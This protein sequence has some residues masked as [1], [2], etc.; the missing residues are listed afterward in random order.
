MGIQSGANRL[1]QKYDISQFV[2]QTKP[3][4]ATLTLFLGGVEREIK[5]NV[6]PMSFS[7]KLMNFLKGNLVQLLCTS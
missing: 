5:V 7:T 3:G 2:K 1:E 4:Y 6:L